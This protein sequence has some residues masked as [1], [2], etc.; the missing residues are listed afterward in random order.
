MIDP[1]SDFIDHMRAHGVSPFDASEIIA[2]DKPRR[3]RLDDDKPKIKTGSYALRI[4]PD[5]FAFGWFINFREAITYKWHAKATKQISDDDRAAYKAKAAAA[6]KAKDA[7]TKKQAEA[8]ASRAQKIWER[9]DLTGSTDYLAR[10]Q[11][12][13]NGARIMGDSVVVPLRNG[14]EIMGLQF[15]KP[16]GEKRFNKNIAKDGAYFSIAKAKDDLSNIVICEGFATGGSLRAAT[17]WP[18][19]VAFDAGNLLPVAT[20]IRKKY[21]A[22][23]II[24]AADNDQWTATGTNAPKEFSAFKHLPGDA[25][26][27]SEWRTAGKLTNT[28]I[29][30]ARKAAEAIGGARVAAPNIPGDDA[31]KRTDWNDIAVTDG[32]EALRLALDPPADDQPPEY[33]EDE[34]GVDGDPDFDWSQVEADPLAVVRPLGYNRGIYYF[35]PKVSGQIVPLSAAGMN[36]FTSL[37]VLAPHSFWETHYS[38]GKTSDANICKTAAND[39]MQACHR[40]GIFQPESTRGVGAWIED[41]KLV[42]NTGD[43]IITESGSQ[44]PSDFKAE[45]VYESGPRVIDLTHEPLGNKEAAKL[46]QASK[47]LCW[48]RGMYADLFAG[49]LVVAPI[50]SA[51]KW[52]PHIWITGRSGSGKSTILGMLLEPV[53]GSIAIRRDGGTTEAGVR[54]ALGCSGRPFILD[55][56][57]SETQQER[58]QMERIIFLARR[59]SSG[60]IVENFNTSFQ[61]R[62]CFCFSAINPRVEQTADKGR[63]TQLELVPDT[64]KD[65]DKNFA[66]LVEFM[67][68]TFTPDYSKALLARTVRNIDAL[69]ANVVTFSLAASAIMGNKRAGDQ[70]GP[71]IAGAYMLTSTG[72][73]S[74]SDAK[75]WMEKQDWFWS[76]MG[77]EESDSHKLLT[78]IMTSRATYDIGGNRKESSVGALVERSQRGDEIEAEAANAAMRGIGIK[79]DDGRIFIAN[80]SPPL[81]KMLSETPW[82]PWARTLGDFPGALVVSKPIYFSTGLTSRCTSIPLSSVIDHASPSAWDAEQIENQNADEEYFR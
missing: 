32:L 22:A 47:M 24:I 4:E 79:I 76:V 60:G 57:E 55:E 8:A 77:E 29:E 61:A 31:A 36:K 10:K 56:A 13:L 66:D 53:L 78:H 23:R 15:I 81:R 17:G 51:L 27:W 21:P 1:I 44:K 46:R 34:I 11:V 25:P 49:W 50:G 14:P 80:Q 42:V 39:L 16:D 73:I 45:N 65:R 26:I 69:L 38:D 68:K 3:F 75:E 54:K 82:I 18:I 74:Y 72:K 71:L 62:S 40:K 59:S 52:R 58:Q 5:G 37:F 63:I 12:A 7:E 35:F 2:D 43:E 30:K 19:I 20:A 28:G 67:G 33:S 9:L 48:K 70:M 64:S 6:R 41:G